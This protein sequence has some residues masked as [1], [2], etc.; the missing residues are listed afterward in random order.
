MILQPHVV[1][2]SNTRT[3]THRNLRRLRHLAILT[4]VPRLRAQ[5][6]KARAS[7]KVA[8]VDITAP[9]EP[10]Q[11]EVDQVAIATVQ[12]QLVVFQA[13]PLIEAPT[14]VSKL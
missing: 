10:L 9:I 2:M 12:H 4:H 8:Q 6:I 14:S 13:E 3:H 5:P 7:A 11:L 1:L